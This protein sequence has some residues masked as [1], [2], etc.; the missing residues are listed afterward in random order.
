[1]ESSGCHVVRLCEVIAWR[2]WQRACPLVWPL[3]DGQL[4][5]KWALGIGQQSFDFLGE[6]FFQLA[7]ILRDVARYRVPHWINEYVDVLGHHDEAD[8]LNLTFLPS[9]VDGLAQ[10]TRPVVIGQQRHSP[11][12]GKRQL[13]EM[14]RL[15][16]M[17][18]L[19]PMM[20]RL[21]HDRDD[22]A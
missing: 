8:Q 19:L 9:D 12:P 4:R 16:E 1:M 14:A 6:W 3:A 15:V 2:Q 11:I 5:Q 18:N 10:P 13:V 21:S 22:I 20:L 17:P 7:Q